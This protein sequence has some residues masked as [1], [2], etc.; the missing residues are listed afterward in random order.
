MKKHIK[1]KIKVRT[2]IKIMG[3]FLSVIILLSSGCAKK[4]RQ[5]LEKYSDVLTVADLLE[6]ISYSGSIDRKVAVNPKGVHISFHL[7]VIGNKNKE[8]KEDEIFIAHIEYLMTNEKNLIEDMKTS[9]SITGIGNRAWYDSFANGSAELFYYVADKNIL[10]GLEGY[11][12]GSDKPP[13]TLINKEGFI[14]LAR[15]IEKRLK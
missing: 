6:V 1:P 7:W 13:S 14:L 2:M 8:K 5:S 10:V 11:A 9:E 12:E 15:L 4:E 3:L